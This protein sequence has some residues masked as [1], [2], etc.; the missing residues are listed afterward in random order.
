MRGAAHAVPSSE[1]WRDWQEPRPSI[2]HGEGSSSVVRQRMD[3]LAMGSMQEMSKG[4]S[5]AAFQDAGFPCLLPWN[6]ACGICSLLQ[7][8]TNEPRATN[9]TSFRDALL[10]KA[11]GDPCAGGVDQSR[12]FHYR[13]AT[14]LV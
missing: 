1:P 7:E 13:I 2:E 8:S 4:F 12:S 14:T 5:V 6:L 9:R 11:W 3:E 10:R